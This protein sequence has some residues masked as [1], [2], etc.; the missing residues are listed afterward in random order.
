MKSPYL[1]LE[2]VTNLRFGENL[3]HPDIELTHVLMEH[4]WMFQ[5]EK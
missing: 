4:S 1:R 5:C 2:Y 3:Q